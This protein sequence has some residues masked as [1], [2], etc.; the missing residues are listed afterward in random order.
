M[1]RKR[2]IPILLLHKSGL[3]KTRKFKKPKY[4]GDPI[5][6]VK[7]FNDK[8]VDEIAIFDIDASRNSSGPNYKYIEKLA[9]ECFSPLCYGGGVT[10]TEQM[11]ELYALGVE[12]IA[13]NEVLFSKPTLLESAS[14][15]FGS[16]SIVAV[17]NVKKNWFGQQC[18]YRYYN[19]K[20]YKIDLV[21]HI[22][23][24]VR[25]G[26]G[27]IIINDVDNEGSMLGYNLS[28]FDNIS[29][30]VDV[31][32]VCCGGG[33]KLADIKNAFEKTNITAVGNGSMFVYNGK[34]RAVLI[35][36]PKAES[37]ENIL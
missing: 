19:N 26:A 5:N 2:V 8:E 9:S 23:E 7:I 1:L 16:Q 14:K 29:K 12:K 17:V 31:P 24:L 28:M 30:S 35:S 15:L 33:G 6:A 4:I 34:H 21:N 20:T 25:Y 18:L 27:E 3:Y 11:K 37:L 22:N 36:Y 10:T 13:L 32:V